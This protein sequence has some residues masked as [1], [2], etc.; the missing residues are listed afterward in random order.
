[1]VD[2]SNPD[3]V[4][5]RFLEQPGEA[6]FP[7]LF[8]AVKGDVYTIA[9]RMLGNPEDALEAFQEAFTRLHVSLG[10][11]RERWMTQS[12]HEVMRRLAY[13][14][15]DRL[16]QRRN[17]RNRREAPSEEVAAMPDERSNPREEA[18]REEVRRRVG[19]IVDNL[20]EHER[21]VVYLHYFHGMTHREIAAAMNLPPGTV[22]ARI[23]R[24]T[25]R[26]ERPLRR[27]GF[28]E[29]TGV[30]AT[31]ATGSSMLLPPATVTAA[32]VYMTATTSATVAMSSLPSLFQGMILMKAKHVVIAAV[33]LCAVGTV[34]VVGLQNDRTGS[35]PTEAAGIS[36]TPS[37]NLTEGGDIQSDSALMEGL[38]ASPSTG[39]GS[40]DTQELADTEDMKDLE[41]E[42]SPEGDVPTA[43]VSGIIRYEGTGE[44]A[45]NVPVSILGFESVATTDA[46]GEFLLEGLPQGAGRILARIDN[47]RSIPAPG[48]S[49]D[50]TLTAGQ[51]TGPVELLLREATVT[52]GR[53][54]DAY[55]DEPLDGVHVHLEGNNE[56]YT[57]TTAEGGVYLLEAL[58][59]GDYT[60]ILEK[61]GY[62]NHA[63]M[64]TMTTESLAKRDYRIHRIGSV[65]VRVVDEKG[66]PVE[67]TRVS[68]SM[69][70]PSLSIYTIPP[71]DEKGV[72]VID[73]FPMEHPVIL[74]VN[75]MEYSDVESKEYKLPYGVTEDAVELVL[76]NRVP[77]LVLEGVVLEAETQLPVAGATVDLHIRLMRRSS[78]SSGRVVMTY[79]TSTTPTN[80]FRNTTSD[81]GGRFRIEV[82][83]DST[84]HHLFVAHDDYSIFDTTELTMGSMETP[85]WV[86]VALEPGGRVTGVVRDGEGDPVSGARIMTSQP[87]QFRMSRDEDRGTDH[88]GRFEIGSVGR[89]PIW[90]SISMD[91]YTSKRIDEAFAGDHLEITLELVE[92]TRPIVLHGQVVDRETG[93]AVRDFSVGHD[94]QTEIQMAR[95]GSSTTSIS[96][97]KLSFSTDDGRFTLNAGNYDPSRR[98]SGEKMTVTVNLQVDAPGYRQARVDPVIIDGNETDIHLTIEMSRGSTFRGRVVDARDGAG[99]GGATV[100]SLSRSQ[101]NQI[102]G[103]SVVEKETTSGPDGRFEI[104]VPD[105]SN[106]L[107]QHPGHARQ[108]IPHGE[109]GRAID[110]GEE[111]PIFMVPGSGVTLMW[112]IPAR[113]GSV[114]VHGAALVGHQFEVMRANAD[115]VYHFVDLPAVEAQLSASSHPDGMRTGGWRVTWPIVLEE[116]EETTI[117]ASE[118]LAGNDNTFQLDFG[119]KF[120]STR[121][122]YIQVTITPVH[123][124]PVA[125]LIFMPDADLPVTFPA[126]PAGNY[127]IGVFGHGR[128]DIPASREMFLDPNTPIILNLEE[129]SASP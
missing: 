27:A 54:F 74:T 56:V 129:F 106:L 29:A 79:M 89:E 71:T 22:S 7:P 55:T 98:Q 16:R 109:V 90:V 114:D 70:L 87:F 103:L 91:G 4:W 99:I 117:R 119:E 105:I 52:G 48:H 61:E 44:R 102:T 62:R 110:D 47:Y 124:D 67:G 37:G 9:F 13:L 121:G 58:Q 50:V 112:D 5:Q 81:E 75:D 92:T 63:E 111:T 97:Q 100:Q 77:R 10:K 25:R 11:E 104:E 64:F 83:G 115:G 46:R 43:S 40:E 73:D 41:G 78:G 34:L 31:L 127:L 108:T 6:T 101:R 59:P 95:G 8:V 28:G 38:L 12:P 1:M 14:E 65:T 30:L 120:Q 3:I 20:P 24:A 33:V 122:S 53:I 32:T 88:A 107:I 2:G 82:E 35:V 86:D 118:F 21:L 96:Q 42:T 45:A 66:V 123:D 128:S 19:Q 15:A 51:E 23:A 93:D 36:T 17:R 85:G 80:T 26:M 39:D 68:A 69:N 49:D 76:K 126:P 57:D 94:R 60:I 18:G 84:H 125:R 113:M 116:G 72:V